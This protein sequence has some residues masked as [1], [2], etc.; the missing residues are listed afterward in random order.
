MVVAAADESKTLRQPVL[1]QPVL[2][3][4]VLRK[5]VLRKPVLR[6]PVLRQPVLRQPTPPTLSTG[7]T[8]LLAAWLVASS[9]PSRCCNPWGG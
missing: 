6:Q 1:R 3:Q 9:Q 2:R 4:P 8:A 5:P 7:S